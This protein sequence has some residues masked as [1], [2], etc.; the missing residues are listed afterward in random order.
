M[1]ATQIKQRINELADKLIEGTSSATE[2]REFKS[3]YSHYR[4]QQNLQVVS[5]GSSSAFLG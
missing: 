3:L 2:D 5:A 4:S 1:H